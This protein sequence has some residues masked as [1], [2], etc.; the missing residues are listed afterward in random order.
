MSY[1]V[2]FSKHAVKDAAK[3]KNSSLQE[4]C[5]KLIELLAQDPFST[6]P[7]YEKLVG[8]LQGFYSRRINIQH[9]LVYE[10]DEKQKL[11]KV[12]RMWSHYE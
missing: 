11:V 9:R 5:Q 2:I 8:D 6:I 12:L 1:K 10:V 3:I 7:P 4:K